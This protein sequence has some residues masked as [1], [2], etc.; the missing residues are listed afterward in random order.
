MAG[1]RTS[2]RR[3]LARELD[4]ALDAE[5]RRH[6][7]ERRPL[8]AV[9]DHDPAQVG[10]VVAQQPQRAQDVGVAL[11]GDE[12][13]DGEDR[14]Q[15][16]LGERRGRDVGAEVH[17]ARVRGAERAG[18]RLDTGR[19]GEHEPRALQRPPHD[20]LAAG[21][22]HDAQDVAAVDRDHQ[23]HARSRVPH[24]VAGGRRVV[25]VDEVDV[26]PPQRERERRR[27]PRAPVLVGPRA[28]RGDER[29]VG[30]RD[31]VE[32]GPQRLAQR[33]EQRRGAP[34]APPG[35]APAGGARA[36]ARR[37]RRRA[38]RAPGGAPTRRA[39][40]SAARG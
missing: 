30:D 6:G 12:V 26:K 27:R 16:R 37:R 32:L 33:L 17:D 19:V 24:R 28:R 29:D 15:R 14:R 25:G 39:R 18:A 36:R 40:G 9:A 35:S 22:L 10:M 34:S 4:A 38:R 20:R 23:R 21:P 5:L 1:R 11:A 8:R 2:I 3:Q 31:A 7:L 13:A